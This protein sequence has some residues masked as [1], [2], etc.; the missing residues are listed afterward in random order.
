MRK[1]TVISLMLLALSACQNQ[2]LREI[3]NANADGP[4]EFI[5]DPKSPLEQPVSYSDLPPPTP[6][7]A[8]RSD[9]SPAQEAVI[10]VGGTPQ[11]ELGR[12][13]ASDAALVQATSRFGV[14][15]NIRGSLAAA[16]A[17]FRRKQ[18]RFTQI[19][20]FP[21]DRYNQVY[22]DQALDP[23]LV[24]NQWRARGAGTPAFPPS[25]APDF[26]Q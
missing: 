18:S 22:D 7:A 10:A 5:I 24:A 21:V 2:G 1:I 3:R 19:R 12:V 11:S 14:A 17:E 15:Q 23:R 6:G 25:T 16:D 26:S 8:N 13:P 9:R 4:D 20:L